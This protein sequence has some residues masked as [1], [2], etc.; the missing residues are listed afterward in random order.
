MERQQIETL[1]VASENAVALGQ[2]VGPVG[3]WKAVA[4]VKREEGLVDSYA[5]RIGRIDRA[6]FL[7]WALFDVPLWVGNMLMVL[8]A[9]LGLGLIAWSYP[10]DGDIAGAVFLAGLGALMVTTHGL[11][12]LVVGYML[13]MR[14][15][16][17]FVGSIGRPQPGV[18]LD[19]ATYLR[20]SPRRRAWMHA[21]G[22][23]V[24]KLIPW[25][26]LGAAIAADLPAWAV[27]ATVAVGAFTLLTDVFLSTRFGEWKKVR[28]EWSLAQSR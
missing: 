19:Y 23:I 10:L 28:R 15:T 26:L 24:T 17:W 16:H 9:A 3:F 2:S 4:A 11:A 8:G 21:S 7:N 5:D 25:L 1:L 27:W 18:K 20:S 22:V 14:F 12:H 6:A 13:G